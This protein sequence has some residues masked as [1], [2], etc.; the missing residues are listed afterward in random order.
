MVATRKSGYDLTGRPKSRGISRFRIIRG[1]L[2]MP[3][4]SAILPR[5]TDP[6]LRRGFP[7]LRFLCG[8]LRRYARTFGTEGRSVLTP[9]GR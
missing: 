5:S 8:S 7:G 6:R 2:C 4:L 3:C 1:R 9:V